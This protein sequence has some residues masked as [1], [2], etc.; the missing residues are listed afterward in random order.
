MTTNKTNNKKLIHS[1][2]VKNVY[3]LDNE[4]VEFE[5]TDR[6]SVFDK[7]IGNEI[8]GKGETLCDT[9]CHWL[10]K[11]SSN[12]ISNHF[13]ERTG[14]RSIRVK[15]V[16]IIT[17][18][19]KILDGKTNHLIPLEFITRHYCAGSLSD[20]LKSGE[21]QPEAVGSKSGETIFPGQRLPQPYFEFS[22]KLEPVD[23]FVE[24]EEALKIA[25]MKPERL[26]EIKSQCLKIDQLMEENLKG[27]NL[28]HVDGK[29]EFGYDK[30]GQLMIIDVFGT[31]DEDRY[32][33]R[34]R[35]DENNEQLE[36]S[37][38]AIRKHYRKIGYKDLLYK[39]RK[40]GEKEPSIPDMPEELVS[41]VSQLY[42]FIADQ[43]IEK[44]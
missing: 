21:I 42:R 14:V 24:L 30:N 25:R 10:E 43:I 4:T 27:T 29:K 6:V 23:R 35:Y 1:G 12:G 15:S 28:I 32:W 11:L 13:L 38:E 9:A 36:L 20:R 7:P 37:K 5:F 34:K 40:E 16:Q 19:S 2:S 33:D 17:D 39:A 22:T 3:K 26:E 18:Y 31:A 44:K 8:P 41:E